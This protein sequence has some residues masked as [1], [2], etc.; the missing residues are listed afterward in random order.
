[1]FSFSMLQDG[2]PTYQQCLYLY[3]IVYLNGTILTNLP[4]KLRLEKLKQAV[5]NEMK[6]RVQ[7]THSI[8]F[9][10]QTISFDHRSNH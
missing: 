9:I 8:N 5:P 10:V 1:M 2:D 6:G 7:V 4:Y 3:D